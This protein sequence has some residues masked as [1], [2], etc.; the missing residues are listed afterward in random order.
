VRSKNGSVGALDTADLQFGAQSAD[1]TPVETAI[2]L[3]PTAATAAAALAIAWFERG[4]I[5]AEHWLPYAIAATLVLATAV[6]AGAATRP[7][8]LHVIA[9]GALVGLAGWAALSL[10]WSPAP[11]LARDEALLTAF[12]AVSFATPLLTLRTALDRTAAVGVV[13]A[14]LTVLAVATA[15]ALVLGADDERMFFDGRLIFPVSYANAQA[16]LM[17]VG[18]W[19]AAALAAR[20]RAPIVV[21]GL[22]CGGAAALLAGWLMS[23]SKG[24]GIALVISGGLVFGLSPGRL[25]L[26]VPVALA[27]VVAFAAASPLTAPF[28]AAGSEPIQRAGLGLLV[29]LAVASA[30][31]F[32]YALADGRVSVSARVR[33]AA[34]CLVLAGLGAVV[35]GAG[36]VFLTRVEDPRRFVEEKWDSFTTLSEERDTGTTHFSSLGSNRYDFWRVSLGEFDRHPW[37]GVGARGFRAAYLEHGRSEETPTR[38]HSLPLE[39]LAEQGLVGFVLLSVAVGLPLVLAARRLPRLPALAAF[40]AGTYWLVHAS[41]DWIWTFPALGVVFFLLLG[42]GASGPGRGAAA[43]ASRGRWLVAPALIALAVLAF[44]PP[45]LASRLTTRALEGSSPDPAADLQRARSLDPL[46]VTPLTA[47]AALARSPQE[48]IGPLERAVELEPRSAGLQYLLGLAY[49]EAGRKEAAR[50]R[51]HIAR[52]LY[53]QGDV[54]RQ[55]LRRA[56]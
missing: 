27:A 18:F 11:S 31:G 14:G 33:S 15:F 24:A 17:V 22:A 40:G 26:A 53:P 5:A 6:A 29:V 12:Y 49:L 8:R 50:E 48:E 54:I 45:Y 19:P 37:A 23:Q 43:L 20:G 7:Q 52:R 21:R 44:T 42:I 25:R 35:V 3:V 2:R 46:S 30:A 13:A 36:V 9:L 51:L 38:A 4:S 55:A 10:T 32:V 47:E 56:R 34:A 41:A 28:R 39:V 1:S 16:A